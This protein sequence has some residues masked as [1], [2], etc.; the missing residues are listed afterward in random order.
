MEYIV[1]LILGGGVL[2]A[3]TTIGVVAILGVL[4]ML[5]GVL[6]GLKAQGDT[7]EKEGPE[8]APEGKDV[9]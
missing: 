2:I 5:G 9:G 4:V 6:A 8:R 3:V 1:E 7:E